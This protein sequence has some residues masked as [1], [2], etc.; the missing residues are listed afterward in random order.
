MLLLADTWFLLGKYVRLSVRMPMWT[1]F[2]LVQPMIWLVI[3]GHLFKNIV[4]L[5]GFPANSYLQFLTP[6]ILVMT[7]LF[8]SSW[9]GVNLLREINFKVIEKMMVTAVARESIILSRIIHSCLTLLVQVW[10][11]L[12]VVLLLGVSI[13]GG[14][15][16]VFWCSVVA[17]FLGIGFSSLS[18][19]LA[20]VFK[21]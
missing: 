8:G 3:F 14:F 19:G 20:M 18:N 1:L 21:K 12:L 16:G 15:V 2:G 5:P 17:A 9:A 7:V 6:A 4:Q 13:P 11:I 10:A